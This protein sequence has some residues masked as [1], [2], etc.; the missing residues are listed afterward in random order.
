MLMQ[1]RI[2][3]E[4]LFFRILTP[5]GSNAMDVATLRDISVLEQD[6]Q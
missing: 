3:A 6:F 4:M 1:F 5:T 2:S